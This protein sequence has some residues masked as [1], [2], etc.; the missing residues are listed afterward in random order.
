M[1]NVYAMPES[2][3]IASFVYLHG[4][5]EAKHGT[6]LCYVSNKPDIAGEYECFVNGNERSRLFLW[7]T[8]TRQIGLVVACDD[9]VGLHEAR[10]L[11]GSD[12]I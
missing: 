12:T 11:Y 3:H 5:L 1:I 6:D 8:P 4:K 9:K 10:E 7:N 2:N